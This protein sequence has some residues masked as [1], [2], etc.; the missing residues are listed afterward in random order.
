MAGRMQVDTGAMKRDVAPKAEDAGTRLKSVVERLEAKLQSL[1]SPWGNDKF[2]KQFA[3]GAN[4]YLA[5][6]NNMRDGA[7]RIHDA[8]HGYAEGIRQAAESMR[9]QDAAQAAS[10]PGVD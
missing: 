5:Y 2:G 1:G 4:G 9:R 7:R 8:L 10:T 6:S 3:D